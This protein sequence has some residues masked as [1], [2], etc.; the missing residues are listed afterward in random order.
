MRRSIKS[1]LIRSFMLIILVTV[2]FL[3]I[4]LING[5]KDHYYKN[6]EDILTSQIEFSTNFYARYFSTENLE[7][8]I[9]DD[10]D[11]FWQHTSA[12]V[13]VLSTDGTVLMDSLG[14]PFSELIATPDITDAMEKGKGVWSGSVSYDSDPVMAVSMPLLYRNTPVGILRFVSSLK[15]TNAV[16]TDIA[17]FLVIMGFAV[18]AVAIIISIFIANSIVKPLAEVTEVANKMADGQ[19]KVRSN[20]KY[21]DEIGKLSHT[22]NYMAEEILRKETLKNDFISSISHELRTPLT[23]IKGW[24]VT[25]KADEELS[26]DIYLDGLDIIENESDRLSRMVEELLDFSRFTSGRI[27]LTKE[28]VDIKESLKMVVYQMMPRAINNNISF[29]V[30]IDDNL[31]PIMGD[32]NRIK[33]VLINVIDNAF[34]FTGKGKVTLKAYESENHL[35]IEVEDDGPG[36]PEEELPYIKEKFYKGKNSKSH[37]GIGLSICDEIMHLH[38]GYFNIESVLGEGTKVELGFPREAS[39]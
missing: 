22:L 21:D 23:S 5:I 18:V 29:E 11:L 37:S 16:I 27:T 31:S 19:F 36:I 13:Q 39:V 32:G 26:R 2:I 17:R 30:D 33:Q 6:V 35:I 14:V 34:K 9:I 15:A 12:Q 4:L 38:E 10:V 7:E 8:T 25:L 3:E 28:M 24:A 1:R 20:V